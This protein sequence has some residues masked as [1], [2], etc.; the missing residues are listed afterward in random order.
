MMAVFIERSPAFSEGRRLGTCDPEHSDPGVSINILV[1]CLLR[2]LVHLRAFVALVSAQ[3][4]RRVVSNLGVDVSLRIVDPDICRRDRVRAD[5]CQAGFRVGRAT[6]CFAVGS[7]RASFPLE[8]E[9]E[10]ESLRDLD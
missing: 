3:L 8:F 1:Y 6:G 5:R 4:A 10:I 9:R 7:Y 2:M